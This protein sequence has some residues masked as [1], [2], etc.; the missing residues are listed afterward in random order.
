[1]A[2]FAAYFDESGTKDSKAIAVAGYISTVDQWKRFEGEWRDVLQEANIPF[3]HM[4]KY[5]SRWGH[6]K[7]WSD[8]KRKM[9]L[10]KLILAIRNR[11]RMPIG[12]AVS[13]ADYEKVYGPSPLINVY[14]F[15]ALQCISLVGKW[16]ER[17]GYQELIAYFL[18]SGAGYNCELDALTS[19]ISG[20]DARK[21]EF[22]FGSLTTANKRDVLPLQA[23]DVHAYE[24]YKEMVNRILPATRLKPQRWSA[25]ALLDGR[26]TEYVGYFTKENLPSPRAYVPND[27]C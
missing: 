5:E 7:P 19:L 16:A 25:L 21:R 27:E 9:I 26:S 2:M 3:F 18:E 14:T 6:Y 11:T 8:F 17:S 15:C 20:S 4:A 13:V 23:A 24:T 1:M 10:E 12:V 22:R